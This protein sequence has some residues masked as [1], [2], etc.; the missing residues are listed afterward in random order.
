MP[1]SPKIVELGSVLQPRAACVEYVTGR[2][3]LDEPGGVE[4]RGLEDEPHGRRTTSAGGCAAVRSAP[5]VPSPRAI[6]VSIVNGKID[7][8][9]GHVETLESRNPAGQGRHPPIRLSIASRKV[10]V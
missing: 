5:S 10:G 3:G 8:R 6:G 4:H 7:W 2:V 1:L 9:T